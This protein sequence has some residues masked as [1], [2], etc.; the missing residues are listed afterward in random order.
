MLTEI[1]RDSQEGD[2]IRWQKRSW[3]ELGTWLAT[4]FWMTE[5]KLLADVMATLSQLSTAEHSHA[6]S[7]NE[8]SYQ[9]SINI[10]FAAQYIRSSVKCHNFDYRSR[11]EKSAQDPRSGISLP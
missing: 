7:D 3:T 6:K 11:G 2:K 9:L 8:F 5:C 1:V 10:N 4:H